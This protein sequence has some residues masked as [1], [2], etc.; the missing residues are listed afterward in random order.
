MR[1]AYEAVADAAEDNV[2]Y[3]ELRFN[4]VALALNQ[5]FSFEDVADWV[6]QAVHDSQRDYKIQVRLIVQMGRHEPQYAPRLAEIAVARRDKGVVAIDLA[7]DEINFPL[8]DFIEVFQWAKR[9]GLYVT[10]HAAEAG[11]ASNVR[12]AIELLGADRIGHGIRAMEDI[13]VIDLISQRRVTLEMCPTSNLQTGIIPKLGQH[14]MFA[15]YQIGIPVTV[16]TDD[17][18]ISNTTLTDEFLVAT[19]GVGVPPRALRDMI[20]NAARAAFLPQLEKDRLVGWFQ[21]A[22]YKKD[23]E[24]YLK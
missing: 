24:G 1:V 2:R 3:L 15:F 13:S 16:N 23:T 9:Q 12:E 19:R 6:I 18:S 17:P 22:L 11:P 4:P 7:G 8:A 20:M 10:V 21:K 5:G 14:P